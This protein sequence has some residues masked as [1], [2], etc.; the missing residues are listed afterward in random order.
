MHKIRFKIVVTKET[1]LLK[2]LITHPMASGEDKVFNKGK[3][4]FEKVPADYIE[5][6]HLFLNHEKI[7]SVKLGVDISVNP[8]ISC[9]LDRVNVGDKIQV[10]YINNKG[11]EFSF[12]EPVDKHIQKK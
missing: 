12:E 10:V 8:Y 7:M 1:N 6:A 9:E 11:K 4:L 2:V 3:D 5:V